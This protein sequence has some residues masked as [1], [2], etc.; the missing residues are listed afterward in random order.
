LLA[1]IYWTAK[2]WPVKSNRVRR[3]QGFLSP[4]A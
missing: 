2:K 4:D 1:A 3:P